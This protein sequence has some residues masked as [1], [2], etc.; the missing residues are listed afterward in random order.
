MKL[1]RKYVVCIKY[2]DLCQK[3]ISTIKLINYDKSFSFAQSVNAYSGDYGFELEKKC[4]D[5]KTGVIDK[6]I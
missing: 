2:I 1:F 6:F 3:P 4:F 5:H